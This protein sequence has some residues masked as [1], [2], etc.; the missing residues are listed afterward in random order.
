MCRRTS[1]IGR[2]FWNQEVPAAPPGYT[3]LL[4]ASV[5]GSRMQQLLDQLEYGGF[6]DDTSR[7]AVVQVN[8]D[9]RAMI[10]SSS[11]RRYTYE[12]P[13]AA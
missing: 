8:D 6:M 1:C 5:T 3:V 11:L 12:R 13:R 10:A 9:A 4:D 7:R 2:P